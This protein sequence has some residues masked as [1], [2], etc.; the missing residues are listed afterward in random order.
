M[1]DEMLP[2]DTP[3]ERRNV[4]LVRE[5]MGIA[6]DVPPGWTAAGDELAAGKA[7]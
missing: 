3:E 1:I 6:Y 2:D 5:S 7:R 4:E